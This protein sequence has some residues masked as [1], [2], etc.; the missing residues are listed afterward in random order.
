MNFVII[1]VQRVASK[2]KI[3]YNTDYEI[4]SDDEWDTDLDLDTFD[5]SSS[6]RTKRSK[7]KFN[8]KSNT[9]KK[10]NKSKFK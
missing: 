10:R 3:D 2:R 6:K 1:P 9:D 7:Q 4:Q 8:R 5:V